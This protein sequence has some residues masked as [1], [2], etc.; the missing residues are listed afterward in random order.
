MPPP[1]PTATPQGLLLFGPG[2]VTAR[3]SGRAPAVAV[4]IGP[5]DALLGVVVAVANAVIK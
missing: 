2:L 1:S 4:G 5:V 3:R